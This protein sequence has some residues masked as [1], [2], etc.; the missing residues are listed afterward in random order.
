M[1]DA[2]WRQLRDGGTASLQGLL[3][4]LMLL[5]ALM[6]VKTTTAVYQPGL[7]TNELLQ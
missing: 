3:Q 4:L 7:Y 2:L 6:M 1:M 5:M